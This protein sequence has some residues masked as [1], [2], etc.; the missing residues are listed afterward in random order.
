[1]KNPEA[2]KIAA[3]NRVAVLAAVLVIA[4]CSMLGTQS[5]PTIH[6]NK[7]GVYDVT[8][9]FPRLG[10]QYAHIQKSGDRL[11]LV[12]QTADGL[13]T[14]KPL[15]F[16]GEAVPPKFSVH[17]RFI[18]GQC[19]IITDSPYAEYDVTAEMNSSGAVTV[20]QERRT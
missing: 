12:Y 1:V 4:L 5:K 2:K 18:S 10:W 19:V 20:H 8:R 15:F 3:A 11:S 14:T 6:P 7:D 17:Y 13:T 9:Q 16:D